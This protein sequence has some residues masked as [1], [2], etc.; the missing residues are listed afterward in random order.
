MNNLLA[1]RRLGFTLI[2]LLVVIAIIALLISVLLPSLNRARAASKTTVCLSNM[3]N[4]SLAADLYANDHHDA[5][6]L[7]RSHGGFKQGGWIKLLKP[8]AGSEALYRCPADES[9]NWFEE[10]KS[11]EGTKRLNSY[12]TNVYMTPKQHPPRGSPDP[13]P[14][15]G[16]THRTMIPTAQGTVYLGEWRETTGDEVPEDHIHA[17][18]WKPGLLGVPESQPKDELAIG[19]HVGKRENYAFADSHAETRRFDETFFYD[20]A[21]QKLVR[22]LWD[23]AFRSRRENKEGGQ[24]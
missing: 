9:D 3:K 23:P 6:P 14:L 19:R 7:S 4:L 17:D 24:P 12:A 21:Q 16:F 2:E 18:R 15:Y 8:Y 20:E 13:R 11:V 5:Y 10:G 1:R 22:D